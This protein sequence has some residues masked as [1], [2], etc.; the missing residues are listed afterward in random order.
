MTNESGTPP[1]FPLW[2][3]VWGEGGLFTEMDDIGGEKGRF[4]FGYISWSYGTE[5]QEKSL[6]DTGLEIYDSLNVKA[7]ATPRK[8]T[9]IQCYNFINCHKITLPSL[10]PLSLS[11]PLEWDTIWSG[12]QKV[13]VLTELI[14]IRK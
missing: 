6:E 7:Y 12:K 4:S 11:A 13:L 9:K 14:V 10:S 3:Q 1:V 2:D 8:K 5:F